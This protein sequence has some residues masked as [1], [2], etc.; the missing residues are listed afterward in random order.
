[1]PEIVR[2]TPD[3]HQ[4]LSRVLA[5]AFE[6]DPVLS[7]LVRTDSK[8]DRAR[9]RFFEVALH[10]VA[11]HDLVFRAGEDLGAA[12]WV[13]PGAWRLGL[14]RELRLLPSLIAISGL[15]RTARTLQGIGAALMRRGL[16]ECDERRLPAYLENSKER[17]LPLYC[18]LGFEVVEEIAFGPGSP[19]QWL[20]WRRG[21][22]R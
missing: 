15:A 1:M 19:R 6:D 7:W 22:S 20:M 3:D 21:L 18:R 16:A 12:L 2:A 14:A 8:R 5:R 17:N 9:R 11:R 10:T 4:P 13:P